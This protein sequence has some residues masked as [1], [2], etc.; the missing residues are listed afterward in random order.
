MKKIIIL[1]ISLF[2]SS[3]FT[4]CATTYPVGIIYTNVKLPL[5]ATQNKGK[6]TKLGVSTSNSYVGVV[7]TGDSSI[8]R[9]VRNADIDEVQYIDWHAK[10]ILG[11]I[12]TYKTLVKG[13]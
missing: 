1:L 13:K 2:T 7:A 11:F 12:G 5:T 8:D 9:A 3:L 4:G 6:S 10:S